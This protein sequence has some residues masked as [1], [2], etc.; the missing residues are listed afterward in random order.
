MKSSEV[1]RKEQST[2]LVSEAGVG[3]G[4]WSLGHDYQTLSNGCSRQYST[5]VRKGHSVIRPCGPEQ[6]WKGAKVGHREK[7]ME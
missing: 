2:V 5:E 7:L 1:Q 3:Q 6:M 4:R